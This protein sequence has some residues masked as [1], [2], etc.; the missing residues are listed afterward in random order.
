M[1]EIVISQGDAG[2]RFDKY[3]GKYL[4]KA[5][6]S[7]IYKMLRKKNIT[8]NEK[9]AT[10]NEKILSGDKVCIFFSDETLDKFSGNA[11]VIGDTSYIAPVV[12]YEDDDILLVDKPSGMLSQRA[13]PEDV[14]LIEH[15]TA[16]LLKS[17]SATDESLKSFHPGICNRLDRNTSGIVAAGKTMKGVQELSLA[18]KE[19]SLH[20]YYICIVAGK[21]LAKS[22]INGYL[23][24]DSKTNKVKIYD[25]DEKSVPGDALLIETE[26]IPIAG[27]DNIT[28][29]KVNLITGRSH[30]IRAHLA[31]V[32]HPVIGDYK[33]GGKINNIFRDKYNV[34][35][36]LLHAY[37]LQIP[38]MDIHVFTKLPGQFI[39]ILKGEKLWEPG[40]QE[41]LE[42]L[43]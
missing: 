18:F 3:L 19:R 11:E 9:K 13:K 6:E 4:S 1:K 26:Y 17:G 22:K 7:F 16:Y 32:N 25:L 10:G 27:N 35:N 30:Q 20:K 28:L 33:Y 31:S 5:T 40:I 24:K 43:H 42:A 29:L 12:V 37:E 36:Q 41:D 23:F 15:I 21:V 34:K 38:D 39:N 8:L 2:Q 14:S